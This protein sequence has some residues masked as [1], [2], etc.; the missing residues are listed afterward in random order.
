MKGSQPDRCRLQFGDLLAA[1]AAN[2]LQTIGSSSPLE[3]VE[4][5]EL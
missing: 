4:G 5:A 3:F 2:A 1:E